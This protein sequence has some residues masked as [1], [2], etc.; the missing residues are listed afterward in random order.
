MHVHVHIGV[1]VHWI[2]V[3]HC[4]TG[5]ILTKCRIGSFWLWSIIIIIIVK[6]V[7]N[8]GVTGALQILLVNNWLVLLVLILGVQLL[9]GLL[10]EGGF[11]GDW[12]L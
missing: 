10:L 2:I 8:H 3:H 1:V 7:I 12:L 4:I 11:C 9:R 6:E 5:L